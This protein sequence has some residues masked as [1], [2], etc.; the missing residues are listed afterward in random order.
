MFE[1]APH[2]STRPREA[3]DGYAVIDLMMCMPNI[4]FIFSWDNINNNLEFYQGRT[5][6]AECCILN[7]KLHTPFLAH[8]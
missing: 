5:I 8:R 1:L 4:V 3:V 7:R 6:V 2:I